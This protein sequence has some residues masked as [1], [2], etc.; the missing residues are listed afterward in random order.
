[1]ICSA[2][3]SLARNRGDHVGLHRRRRRTQ[4]GAST[5]A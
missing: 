2:G 3:C 1:L 5:G 4:H